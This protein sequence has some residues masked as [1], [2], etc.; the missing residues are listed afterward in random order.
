MLFTRTFSQYLKDREFADGGFR[1]PM[2]VGL[3]LSQDCSGTSLT[4]TFCGSL[5]EDSELIAYADDLAL[6][7]QGGLAVEVE[8]RA[9][10]VLQMVLLTADSEL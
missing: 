4:R 6:T 8:L 5:A 2:T 1:Y 10:Q 7:V 9:N 3:P